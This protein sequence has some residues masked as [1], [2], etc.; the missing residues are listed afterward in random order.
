MVTCSLLS[1]EIVYGYAWRGLE[2]TGM[3]FPGPI[4]PTELPEWLQPGSAVIHSTFGRGVIRC[5]RVIKHG[6][7]ME[8]EFERGTKVL[9]PEFGI[10]RLRPASSNEDTKSRLQRVTALFRRK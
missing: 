9:S 7:A 10:P 6:P 8:I 1:H 3:R 2:R 5:Y 4:D